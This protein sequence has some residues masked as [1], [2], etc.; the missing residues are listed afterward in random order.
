MPLT[1]RNVIENL[2]GAAPLFEIDRRNSGLVFL[3]L[4]HSFGHTVTGPAA[5][6]HRPESRLPPRPDRRRGARRQVCVVP[7]HHPGRDADVSGLPLREGQAGRVGEPAGHRPGR[8]EVP[9]LDVRQG[10]ETRAERRDLGGLRHH[11]VRPGRVAEPAQRSEARHDRQAAA[12]RR[13]RDPR[14]RN[15]RAAAGRPDGDVARQRAERLPRLPRRRHPAALPGL[16][17]PAVVRHRRPGGTR[18]RRLRRLPRPAQALPEGRRRDDLAAPTRRTVRPQVP[19]DR[20]AGRASPS[21]ASRPTRAAASS[22]SP[23]SRSN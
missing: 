12:E 13:G 15:R 5:A 3:P 20:Q 10:Q 7:D 9:G 1:H 11:R 23:P 6:V 4:F 8:G 14:P 2:R 22:Y 21:R 17:R 19:A 16:R 18:R